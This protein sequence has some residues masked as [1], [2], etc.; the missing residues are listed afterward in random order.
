MNNQMILPISNLKKVN[1]LLSEGW[2]YDYMVG[3][4]HVLL[5]KYNN[6]RDSAVRGLQQIDS[7]TTYQS[8]GN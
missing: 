7:F 1:K 3:Q 2:I 6:T 4:K 5:R 8:G